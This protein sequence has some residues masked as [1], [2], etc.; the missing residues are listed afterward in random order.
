MGADELSLS[1]TQVEDARVHG[2]VH[3]RGAP[4]DERDAP[5]LQAAQAAHAVHAQDQR[6]GAADPH[7][8]RRRHRVGLHTRQRLHGDERLRLP[9]TMAAGPG[10]PPRRPH[11]KRHG[12]GGPE[13]AARATAA[14]R[15][16]PVRRRRAAPLVGDLAVVRGVRG[17]LLPERRGRAGGLRAAV[18]VRRG[19][20]ERARG[21]ARRAVVAAPL[22]ARRP[23]LPAHHPGVALLGAARGA[24][25]R[26]VPARWLHPEPP[27]ADAPPGARRGRP[28]VRAPRRRPAPLLPLGAA[29]PDADHDVHDRHRH[30]VHAL[31]RRGVPRGA[32]R[33][34]V[35]GRPG[36]AGGRAGVRGRRAPRRG[37]DRAAQCRPLP[38]QPLRRRRAA[39]RADGAVV[40]TGHHLPGRAKQRNYIDVIIAICANFSRSLYREKFGRK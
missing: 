19:R 31:R 3:H 38:A 8:W 18:V 37:G 20:A 25:L 22:D 23:G 26:A 24:Q 35:D 40:R 9:G 39:V 10:G 21:Q 15:G 5:H 32:P 34:G 1:C 29:Q 36:G 28:R 27:A 12:R 2:A 13:P 7:Q 4:A 30:A 16:L 33:R 17:G 14:H 6:A 11:P